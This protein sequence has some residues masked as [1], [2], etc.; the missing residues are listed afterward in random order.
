MRSKVFRKYTKTNCSGDSN[1]VQDRNTTK[2]HSSVGTP[3]PV[4][5]YVQCIYVSMSTQGR[6]GSVSRVFHECFACC[7]NF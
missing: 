3:V 4:V 1:K 6:L 7:C 5:S 2:L